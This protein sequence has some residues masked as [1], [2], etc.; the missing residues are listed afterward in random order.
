MSFQRVGVR[1]A[2]EAGAILVAAIV[3]GPLLHLV[4]WEVGVVVFAVLGLGIW[5]ESRLAEQQAAPRASAPSVQ[6]PP[7][8]EDEPPHVRVNQGRPLSE[9]LWAATS[10]PVPDPD[11]APVAVAPPPAA[12]PAVRVSGPP[13]NVWEL[14]RAF[15]ASGTA[16]DEQTF[17]LQYLRDYAGTDGRLPPEFD[18]L[19]GES[20][21]AFL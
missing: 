4:W 19:V 10:A 14:E 8:I 5:I 18:D 15:E 20:F 9:L 11:P 1:F 3:A 13:Y 12:A 2:A 21:A 16:N 7:V 6:L 17:L